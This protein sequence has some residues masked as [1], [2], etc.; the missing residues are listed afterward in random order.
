MQHLPN[1]GYGPTIKVPF[2]GQTY[3][4]SAFLEYPQLHGWDV[5]WVMAGTWTEKGKSEWEVHSF[6]QAWLFFGLMEAVMR[7]PLQPTTCIVQAILP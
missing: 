2:Y 4:G 1:G 5:E 6:L 7:M 3:D